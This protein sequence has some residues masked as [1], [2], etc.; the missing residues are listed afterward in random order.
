MSLRPKLQNF[1]ERNWKEVRDSWL[2]HIPNFQSAGARPDPGLERLQPLLDLVL[3][4]DNG[5]FS[6]IDG[7][8]EMM[9]WEAVFLFHKCSHTNL[10]AQRL[11]SQGM[12]SWCLFNAYHSAYLG[13]RGIMALLGVALPELKGHQV[14]IDIYPE[15]MKKRKTI[16]PLGS[17]QFQE[18]V[19]VPLAPLD[20][21]DLWEAFQRVINMSNATCWDVGIRQELLDLAHQ[22]ITPPR[23]RFL[24]RSNH[25][26]LTDLISDVQPSDLTGFVGTELNAEDT[27]FLLRLSFS[28]YRL[29]QQLMSDLASYSAV[30]KT[31]LDASRCQ[32]E[33][34]ALDLVSYRNFVSQ[35]NAR[36]EGL[37]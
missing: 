34:E 37:R 29:F 27:G 10:A 23:N 33:S 7:L 1:R 32:V 26:P 14:A 2:G 31:Q 12:Q 35:M 13:A 8:R 19:I 6:D 25:W 18:F 11:G 3:P 21:R 5:R 4:R 30:I 22:K 16:R 9:L 36:T 28:V 20:Q 17:S 15:P 24:Y